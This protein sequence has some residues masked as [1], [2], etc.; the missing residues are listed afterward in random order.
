MPKKEPDILNIAEAFSETDKR[1]GEVVTLMPNS[2]NTVRPV[3]L[4]RL[5]LSVPTLKS[6]PRSQKHQINAMN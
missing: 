6:T 5:G 4:M 1:T 3:A 2:N